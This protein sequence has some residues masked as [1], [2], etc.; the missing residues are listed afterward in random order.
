MG[1]APATTFCIGSGSSSPYPCAG[2]AAI[3]APFRYQ[4]WFIVFRFRVTTQINSFRRAIFDDRL[5]FILDIH[6]KLT[7]FIA[8]VFVGY[9]QVES[10]IFAALSGYYSDR[11]PIIWTIDCRISYYRPK[12]GLHIGR[13][14]IGKFTSRTNFQ[15][16]GYL[17]GWRLEKSG[18]SH[19]FF[20]VTANV[21]G[22]DNPK[23]GFFRDIDCQTPFLA[24]IAFTCNRLQK[25][26]I[27]EPLVGQVSGKFFLTRSYNTKGHFTTRFANR[28]VFRGDYWQGTKSTA[29]E[30]V[31]G[32]SQRSRRAG[33]EQE[34]AKT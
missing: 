1:N 28:V 14:G 29:N 24:I 5:L 27:I 30:I 15:R 6:R 7:I 9:L 17:T 12:V 21:V 33:F 32:G 8:A 13:T 10:E 16:T 22:R 25:I 19:G 20:A 26:L 2:N 3:V 31:Q 11:H 18:C 34:T 4:T 23:C